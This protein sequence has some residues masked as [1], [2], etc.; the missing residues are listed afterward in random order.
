MK[1]LVLFV[2]ILFFAPLLKAQDILAG[3]D[4]NVHIADSLYKSGDYT[5]ALKYYNMV[6]ITT[7]SDPDLFYKRARTHIK[8]ND[9]SKAKRDLS[10]AARIGSYKSEL[11]RDSLMGRTSKTDSQIQFE[12]DVEKYIQSTG[13]K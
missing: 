13:D 5:E 8:L 6:V 7:K 2:V 12:K 3:S 1:K 10:R 9:I 11:L 4:I